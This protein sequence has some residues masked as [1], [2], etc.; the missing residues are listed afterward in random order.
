[1]GHRSPAAARVADVV[2]IEDDAELERIGLDVA[3]GG[4]RVVLVAVGIQLRW[5][6]RI[7]QQVVKQLARGRHRTVI[8]A[9]DDAAR[10]LTQEDLVRWM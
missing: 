10:V 2:I 6:V 7:E 4:K 1:M 3:P 9:I 5:A 8:H